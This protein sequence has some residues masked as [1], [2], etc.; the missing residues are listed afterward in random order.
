MPMSSVLAMSATGLGSCPPTRWLPVA[1]WA[2]TAHPVASSVA[3]CHRSDSP[4]SV[5]DVS[6]LSVVSSR[7]CG[8]SVTFGIADSA[9]SMGARSSARSV[10]A[11]TGWPLA[12]LSCVCSDSAVMPASIGLS[13]AATAFTSA[14]GDTLTSVTTCW[15][16]SSAPVRSSTLAAGS[17]VSVLYDSGPVPR[18][19]A[20]VAGFHWIFHVSPSWLA[21]PVVV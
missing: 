2:L 13:S 11:V 21:L 16:S 6:A 12:A 5:G 10:T 17:G 9:S 1:V 4:D 8:A 20:T 19:G 14:P 15:V 7:V 18:P 3:R